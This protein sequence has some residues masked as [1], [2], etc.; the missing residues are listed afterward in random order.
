MNYSILYYRYYA[1]GGTSLLGELPAGSGGTARPV[2]HN[3]LLIRESKNP[4][5]KPGWGKTGKA[6][7]SLT[8]KNT[9]CATS[10]SSG[11]GMQN[12]VLVLR[13]L[14]AFRDQMMKRFAAIKKHHRVSGGSGSLQGTK[15]AGC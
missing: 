14:G 5:G 10:K 2:Y 4:K 11:A 7:D 13:V 9:S 15:V 1:L 3:G 6:R 12:L 8:R